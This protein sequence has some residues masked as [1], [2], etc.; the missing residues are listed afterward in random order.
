[1][2]ECQACL[3]FLPF[4]P[5]VFS[6]K[7]LF[8]LK[9]THGY[10]LEMAIDKIINEEG[11]RI[12]WIEFVRTAR[13]NEWYDFQT[14]DALEVGLTDADVPRAFRDEVLKK[15]KLVILQELMG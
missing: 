2:V 1:M 9:A 10:P 6:G 5:E 14:V 3:F 8:D 12:D 15:V 4:Q 11:Y 7:K 13:V